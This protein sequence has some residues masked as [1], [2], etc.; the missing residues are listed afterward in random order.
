MTD[1][2]ALLANRR[3]R[4][5]TAGVYIE[6]LSL[7]RDGRPLQNRQLDTVRNAGLIQDLGRLEETHR[8]GPVQHPN[9][10]VPQTK[11]A[12]LAHAAEA[13]IPVVAPP[14]VE[15][16]G[17]HP[18]LVA[19]APRHDGRLGDGPDGDEVVLAAREDVFPVR[20]P[21]EAG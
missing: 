13:V 21:A 4:L 9:V 19:L 17:R 20:G 14:R 3:R 18:R 16:D 10:K 5:Q 11:P 2:L 15:R 7:R 6:A 8:L 12:V 1:T